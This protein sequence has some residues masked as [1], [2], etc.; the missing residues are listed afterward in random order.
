MGGV[1]GK[2]GKEERRG[3]GG[4]GGPGRGKFIGF[5][6]DNEMRIMYEVHVC[7]FVFHLC[8]SFFV[9]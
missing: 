3:W 5:I 1:W 7:E 4:H 2:G 8:G 6:Y 9:S